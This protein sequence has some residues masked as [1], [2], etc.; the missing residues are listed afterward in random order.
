MKILILA[1]L[2]GLAA[3]PA[4]ACG[5]DGMF[6]FGGHGYRSWMTD[7]EVEATR[8]QALA[9]ARQAF[10]ARYK[11]DAAANAAPSAES[12]KTE[13]SAETSVQSPPEDRLP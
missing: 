13:Q 6:G 11:L 3:M 5:L 10:M 2:T 1:A 9:D 7:A 12:A 4:T 8:Q